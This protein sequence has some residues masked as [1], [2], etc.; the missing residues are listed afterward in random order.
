MSGGSEYALWALL[1]VASVTDLVWGNIFNGVTF[2]FLVVGVVYRF[3]RAGIPEGVTALIA[4]AVAFIFFFPLWRL[5]LFAAGDVK[6]L[7]AV[8]AWSDSRLVIE[9]ALGAILVGAV[10][11]SIVL[12]RKLGLMAGLRSV[13]E[14]A[15]VMVPKVKSHRMPF[16]PAFL[17]A[18]FIVKIAEMY[19]WGFL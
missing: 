5:K 11:G 6:L 16:A 9:L 2:A 14:H 8:G 7:M 17:C 12:V 19:H 3:W 18:F 10:V 1:A 4:I 13:R 15:R